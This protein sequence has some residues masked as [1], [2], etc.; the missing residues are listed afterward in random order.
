[1]GLAPPA[2]IPT[3]ANRLLNAPHCEQIGA[4]AAREYQAMA[5][6]IG[7]GANA[8]ALTWLRQR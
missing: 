5:E 3:T 1:V 4:A 8:D 2:G 7:A 6:L